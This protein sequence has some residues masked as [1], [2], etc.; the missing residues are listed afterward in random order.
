MIKLMIVDDSALMRKHLVKL[1]EQ[2]GDFTLCT[3]RTGAEALAELAVF[4]PDVISLDINMPEMDGMTALSRIM[5][6]R[7][8]PVVMVSSLTEKGALATF[9]ALSLGAVDY[10]CKPGGT[11]SLSIDDIHAELISKI[12]AA[13]KAKIRKARGL[14]D[15]IRQQNR[16][17]PEPVKKPVEPRPSAAKTAKAGV[18][19]VGVSTGGP[20]TLEEILPRLPADFPWTVV[21]A[22]HMPA[23]FTGPFAKRMG[24]LCNLPVLEVSKPTLLEPGTIY[25]GR[26]S[27]D[28]IFSRRGTGIAALSQPENRTYLWHPSVELMVR[29]A[30]EH[31]PADRLIGVM[32]TGMGYDGADAMAELHLRGGR[33]IAESEDTAVVFGMPAELINRGGA[34]VVAPCDQVATHLLRWLH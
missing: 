30:L 3:C 10:V 25:I 8:C 26:G 20:R 4:Q 12:R 1:F 22:Q 24:G 5:V 28:V 11:I 13:A 29:S 16:L 23:N 9:E 34:T 27:A 7:P 2:E 33:T 14:V 32:L 15:R 31:Y 17:A 18:V 21:V 6:E 19:L